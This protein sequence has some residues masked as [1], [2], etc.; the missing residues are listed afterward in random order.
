M[1]HQRNGFVKVTRVDDSRGI[2][3]YA[4]KQAALSGEVELSDTLSLYRD[5]LTD[6]P[7]VAL[8]PHDDDEHSVGGEA[9]EHPAVDCGGEQ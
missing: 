7:R 5:R 9:R 1:W 2:V 4:T 3:V 8:Y 6:R